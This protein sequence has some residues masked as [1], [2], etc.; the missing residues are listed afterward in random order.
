MPSHNQSDVASSSNTAAQISEAAHQAQQ[1]QQAAAFRLS[2][3]AAARLRD[4][5][6]ISGFQSAQGN[7]MDQAEPGTTEVA[8]QLQTALQPPWLLPSSPLQQ[9]ATAPCPAGP[10]EAAPIQSAPHQSAASST[11][12]DV[13]K[14]AAA[15][16]PSSR[17]A[18]P[19]ENHAAATRKRRRFD[20]APPADQLK[21]V[22]TAKRGIGEQLV[23]PPRDDKT[24][25]TELA[26]RVAKS[27]DHD[28]SSA[29]PRK[30]TT[31]QKAPAV[32]FPQKGKTSTAAHK[33]KKPKPTSSTD[34]PPE[35]MQKETDTGGIAFGWSNPRRAGKAPH[36]AAAPLK[37]FAAAPT[38]A[39]ATA[40]KQQASAQQAATAVVSS[41]VTA[42]AVQDALAAVQALAPAQVPGSFAGAANQQTLAPTEAHV[43]AVGHAVASEQTANT[44]PAENAAADK[45]VMRRRASDKAAAADKARPSAAHG[46]DSSTVTSDRH[47]RRPDKRTDASD[48]HGRGSDRR[49]DSSD[50]PGHS[51]DKRLSSGRHEHAANR[52]KSH[53]SRLRSTATPVSEL[54]VL[55]ATAAEPTSVLHSPKPPAPPLPPA[56]HQPQHTQHA[57]QLHEQQ[58]HHVQQAQQG[59]LAQQALLGQQTQHAQQELPGPPAS[60]AAKPGQST[61][62]LIAPPLLPSISAVNGPGE[63]ASAS[64]PAPNLKVCLLA[65]LYCT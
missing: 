23:S 11:P 22:L 55:P 32:A 9:P 52:P 30:G 57:Q 54:Q 53:E 46:K 47:G 61:T 43:S 33:D 19:K 34:H 60:K 28:S 10:S 16:Q 2:E 58:A 17:D 64:G 65:Y 21:A 4:Q 20:D 62:P 37:A 6:D 41:S 59:Q 42:Q 27:F 1:A 3:K 48:R 40:D 45:A 8:G 56:A 7:P 35:A 12:T 49:T 13:S 24:A 36:K 44:I 15:A 51:S 18:L 5:T 31:S 26:D 29:Q 14:Y 50:R 39:P 25:R 38:A 63:V